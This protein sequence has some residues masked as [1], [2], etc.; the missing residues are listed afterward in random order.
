MLHAGI[1]VSNL[2]RGLQALRKRHGEIT[3]GSVAGDPSGSRMDGRFT[4]QH[5]HEVLEG[6]NNGQYAFAFVLELNVLKRKCLHSWR[7][8][9]E[10][11][12]ACVRV[13]RRAA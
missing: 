1:T 3:P 11:D 2:K 8:Q 12:G 10:V 4:F 13:R 9:A 6:L 5:G 7:G